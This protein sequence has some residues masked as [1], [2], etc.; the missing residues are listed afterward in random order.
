[1]ETTLEKEK[2]QADGTDRANVTPH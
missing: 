2:I 1:M